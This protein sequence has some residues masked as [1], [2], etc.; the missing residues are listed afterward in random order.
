MS[1]SEFNIHVNPHPPGILPPPYYRPSPSVTKGPKRIARSIVFGLLI[2]NEDGRA[3]FKKTYDYELKSNH[4]E[5][6]GIPLQLDDLVI[7]KDMAFGCCPAPRRLE[8]V[9]D[10]LVITQ[11]ERGPFIHDGPETYDEV[12]QEDRKPIPGLKEE[13]VKTWLEKEVGK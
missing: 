3:W 11:I 4:S 5:D 6:L 7:E 13:K 10:Y 12:I 2:D 8:L 9:D 1:R